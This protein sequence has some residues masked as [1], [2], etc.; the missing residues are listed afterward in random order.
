VR[1]AIVSDLH[2]GT[3]TAGDLLRRRD[4]RDALAEEL[5]GVDRVVLL[6]DALELRDGALAGALAAASPVFAW[7]AEVVGDRE[8]ILV[9]GNHDHHLIAPWLERRV[10]EGAGGLGLEQAVEPLEGALGALAGA[11]RPAGLA[12]AYPGL[13]IR[14]DVYATHG[15]YLDRHLRTP[16]LERLGISLVERLLGNQPDPGPSA[17]GKAGPGDP[18]EYEQVQTPVYEFLYSLAQATSADSPRPE[19]PSIRVWQMLS[20]KGTRAERIRG[21]LLGSVALPGA[22][23]VANRLGLGPVRSDLSPRGITSAALT[24]M[25]EVVERLRI[26]AEHVIF[27]HTHRR[28]PLPGDAGWAQGGRR[29][30]NTGSWVFSPALAGSTASGSPYWPGTIALVDD[31]GPPRLRHLLDGW[32]RED[33]VRAPAP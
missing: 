25:F 8:L 30:W 3:G 23:G 27:G 1:T 2:L 20:G 12:V 16:T 19:G 24:A 5:A 21:W 15:H 17:R 26:D 6:G 29:L 4:V 7:L 11:A 10:F 13:W 9:P 28:G 33:L 18:L 32:A 14:P 31:D 22:V